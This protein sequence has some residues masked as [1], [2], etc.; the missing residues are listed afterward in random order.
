MCLFSPRLRQKLIKKRESHT[1]CSFYKRRLWNCPLESNEQ[2]QKPHARYELINDKQTASL[3][4]IGN[5]YP[6]GI[7]CC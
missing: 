3:L 6:Q 5:T 2:L 7:Y 4:I 1:C